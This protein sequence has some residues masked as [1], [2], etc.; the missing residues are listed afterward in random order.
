M[1]IQ[2]KIRKKVLM[3]HIKKSIATIVIAILLILPLA[4]CG[5][6]QLDDY[7]LDDY[8]YMGITPSMTYDQ[9]MSQF[10]N[11]NKY[12]IVWQHT[13]D[14]GDTCVKVE[15]V[16][17]HEFEYFGYKSDNLTIWFDYN[18]IVTSVRSRINISHLGTNEGPELE[19]KIISILEEMGTCTYSDP[20]YHSSDYAYE[21]NGTEYAVY[22]YIYKSPD[23]PSKRYME[24][25]LY[26]KDQ[27][28]GKP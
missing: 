2:T 21:I 15:S 23:Y 10:E 25:G 14:D 3:S 6:P 5:G 17:P 22:F 26:T 11:S 9:V 1:Y 19:S 12:D 16:K 7:I 13:Y 18:N 27:Y 4:G 24:V 28:P 8:I 20:K